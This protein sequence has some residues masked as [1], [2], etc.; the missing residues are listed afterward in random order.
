MKKSLLLA[1][2][3]LLLTISL[4][5]AQ[6]Q[7]YDGPDD[8]AGD[9]TATREGFLSG[10]RV[11][12]YFQNT[13]ELGKWVS[14]ATG[15]LWSKWPNNDNGTRMT[16]GIGLMIGAKVYVDDASTPV[17]DTTQIRSRTDVHDLYFLQTSY[18]E[19][20]DTDPTGTVEWGFYPCFGYFNE[21][22][23]YPAMTNKPGS[24]PPAGWPA[25]G[26]S[27]KWPG[28]W[29]GRFGR[30]VIYA[31]QEAYFVVNDAHD[32]E[33]LGP[34]DK[35]KYY[36]RPGKKIGDID[37][38]KVTK[39]V[40]LPW[41]GLGIRVEQRGFQWSNPQARDCIFWEYTV[42]NTSDYD[43]PYVAF[44]YWVDNGI[45]GDNADDEFG[46]FNRK[47]DLAYSWDRDGLGGGGL[48]T[49]TMGFAYLESPGMAYD[50][51]DNDE[52]GLLD[53]KR[54]NGYPGD[55]TNVLV[56]PT[57]GISNLQVFLE[58][59]QYTLEQ[60]KPHYAAD[61]DQDWEDGE[62]LNGDGI[63][64]VSEYA[65]D[66]V[67]LDG[68]GPSE[69]N[70]TAPDEGECN[71]RPDYD[72]A[73]GCEPNFAKTDVSESDMVGLTSFQMYPIPSHSSE[74]KWFRG[75]KSMWIVMSSD[76]LVEYLGTVSNLVETFASGPFPLYQGR[77]ERISMS[78]LHSYDPLSGL[79]SPSHDAPALYE[80]KKIVQI[81][82]ER[83]Y[84]FASPPKMPTLQ[85]TAGDGKVIL[86]WDDIADTRTRDPFVG[87][88]NDF[89]GYK[90]FRATDKFFSDAMTIT[91]GYGTPSFYN[92][93]FQCDLKD[94]LQ[95]FTDFGLVNGMGYYLGSET[96]IVHFFTDNNVQNGR[97][98][99]YALVAYD[100]G[101]PQIEPG[102]APSENEIVVE[103]NEAEEII[104]FGKNVQIVVPRTTA[105][106]YTAPQV[107]MDQSGV[108]FGSG[109]ITPTILAEGSLKPGHDYQLRF[110]V[111]TLYTVPDYAHGFSYINNGLEIHDL[112]DGDLLV[113]SESPSD[114][115]YDNLV[116]EDTLDYWYFNPDAPV[117]TDIFE[118]LSLTLTDIP[119]RAR[120]D[121]GKSGWLTGSSNMRVTLTSVETA[122]FPWD[123][124]VVFTD[125][126]NAYTGRVTSKTMRNE[127]NSRIDRTQLLVSQNFSFYV[128]N[129]SFLDSTGNYEKMDLVVHDVDKD[130]SFDMLKD[131]ILVGPVTTKGW[132]AGTAF[133]LDFNNVADA[134]NLPKANDVYRLTFQRPY[135]TT[136]NV[137]F[138][139]LP[140]AEVDK[141]LITY[142]MANIKVVPN[143]YVATNAMEPSVSNWQLNQRR[144]LMF[145]HLP[146]QCE[147]KIFT[148]SGVL[149][150]EIDVQND[151]ANGMAQ[152]DLLTSEGLEIA[153]GVY[154]FYVKSQLTGDEFMGKFAVVK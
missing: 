14:G 137:S 109:S 67:G 80:Q 22:Q 90:L 149:V 114:F 75:D 26:R 76:T 153:A 64:Q 86:T 37:A 3:I 73:N 31:Q 29:D 24:W 128:I 15:G 79:T 48:P 122:Y 17:T 82:Y 123:Y 39:Q 119:T 112:T 93:I 139:V 65:G 49:G 154:I 118:G 91:D 151:A 10:N 50:G 125:D 21:A 30:G 60:L 92:P 46:Y 54:D 103:T 111:D 113:Y 95:G 130:G 6:G 62:D 70:Y 85:A 144:R 56:G 71:H 35:Y 59:F 19:E 16:D 104:A 63:Y 146:A 108:K 69:L 57:D 47:L 117:T 20:M 89:E 102:I 83:D 11:F 25:K 81:I 120:Y 4:V 141:S 2:F 101:A 145:T 98:Y 121:F 126:P 51:V 96:G 8:E 124:D 127:N 23:D 34:E 77:S 88:A 138:K 58:A 134:A 133:I 152:W 135:M 143:P 32:Q 41:G 53:E 84:R 136:D 36:P 78:E 74:D 99:F 116:Y 18:R 147:I 72:G 12:T 9:I 1:A 66:D 107:A 27:L 131:R 43:I 42:A 38:S 105:S 55:P 100:Y 45:G 52:D 142:S 115:A 148:M 61:E 140:Q 110:L 94:S 44:G 106:G 28:E 68:V 150:D 13:T 5:Q 33:W 132:W 87:N 129:K 40:G 7:L 97:T